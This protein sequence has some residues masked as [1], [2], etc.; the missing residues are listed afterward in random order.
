M[1]NVKVLEM[2]RD[3][4]CQESLKGKPNAKKRYTAMKKYLC[5]Y[6]GVY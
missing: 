6:A 1:H 5:Y 2:L 4:I 3:E